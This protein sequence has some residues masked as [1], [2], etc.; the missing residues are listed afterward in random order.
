MKNQ[1]FIDGQNL[2]LGTKH[3]QKPWKIDLR[4][5]QKYLQQKYHIE[6][7]YYFL[8]CMEQK[9]QKIYQNLQKAGF[10]LIFRK[11]PH[12]LR[13]YKK[14]N[15]D[16]DIVFIIMR[17]LLDGE[18][19]DKIYLVSGDGDYFR[20]IEYLCQHNLLGKILHPNRAKAS[21]LYKQ[22]P[23]NYYDYLDAKDIKRKISTKK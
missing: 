4:R 8:G 1:A 18:K 19:I 12:N 20:M 16:T 17:K 15:V 14:G 9:Y 3:C 13:S 11:H 21:S 6:K 10:I 2:H 7:A 23:P 5:F 22:L